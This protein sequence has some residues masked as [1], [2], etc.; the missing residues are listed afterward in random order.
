MFSRFSARLT[1]LGACVLAVICV[2]GAPSATGHA[3]VHASSATLAAYTAS[4]DDDTCAG[5]ANHPQHY[6]GPNRNPGDKRVASHPFLAASFGPGAVPP[7]GGTVVVS[8]T[9]YRGTHQ[10][11]IPRGATVL[12][13]WSSAVATGPPVDHYRVVAV[14]SS[15]RFST[16]IAL[17]DP[18]FF[19]FWMLP[20]KGA[21]AWN[22]QYPSADY[23][24]RQ[25]VGFG[26]LFAPKALI[27][28]YT[29]SVGKRSVNRLPEPFLQFTSAIKPLAGEVTLEEQRGGKWE[30]IGVLFNDGL[31]KGKT[32]IPPDW[33]EY[34]VEH[35][36]HHYRF[37]ADPGSPY[38]GTSNEATVAILP[39]DG[40]SASA[41]TS[42]NGQ[43]GQVNLDALDAQLAQAY[44]TTLYGV[45]TTP[46]KA[47]TFTQ[48]ELAVL[49]QIAGDI[50]TAGCEQSNS[51]L[52]G[53]WDHAG[54]YLTSYLVDKG[55]DA[56]AKSVVEPVVDYVL[57]QVSDSVSGAGGYVSKWITDTAYDSSVG[58][59]SR[60]RGDCSA[61]AT[62]AQSIYDA[63]SA[64][65]GKL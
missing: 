38:V 20:V 50:G 11:N 1:A 60:C 18:E 3:P 57:T 63:L 37:A 16:K 23:C 31:V 55:E 34:D 43:S 25:R 28:G 59:T 12:L 56:V 36:V 62:G 8:G 30:W 47:A 52:L 19:G 4:S 33:D 29:Q 15:G 27:A 14:A 10:P 58:A 17:R 46:A 21:R 5:Y 32:I 51:A 65:A 13:D 40:E 49:T 6:W 7:A 39:L 53:V 54:D 45:L 9:V 44:C 24:I 22:N 42:L 2:T 48:P 64:V 61:I 41:D 26:T 35:L